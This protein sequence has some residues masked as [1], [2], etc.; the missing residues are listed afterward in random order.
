MGRTGS[1]CAVAGSYRS[2]CAC[3]AE[4]RLKAGERRPP[5]PRCGK[6]VLFEL[7][8]T[9]RSEVEGHPARKRQEP[10]R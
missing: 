2:N 7:S 4:I 6:S 8:A 10:D 5:C 3:H 9:R 1:I